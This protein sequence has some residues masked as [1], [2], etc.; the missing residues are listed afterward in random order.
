MR[1]QASLTVWNDAKART[2][3]L[4]SG[5]GDCHST[6]T[7]TEQRARWLIKELQ[8]ELDKLPAAVTAA[9]LGI[10]GAPV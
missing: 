8:D 7:L 4:Y 9:D 5:Y 1:T 3:T 6:V 10:E 2:L